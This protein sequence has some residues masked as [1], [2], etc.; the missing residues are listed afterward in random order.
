MKS[1]DFA[2]S[3][4]DFY[5]LNFAWRLLGFCY[6]H[7]KQATLTIL[8]KKLCKLWTWR[9]YLCCVDNYTGCK[10]QPYL[11]RQGKTRFLWRRLP[12]KV[13]S[14]QNIFL[15]WCRGCGTLRAKKVISDMQGAGAQLVVKTYLLPNVAEKVVLKKLF[16]VPDIVAMILKNV[17]EK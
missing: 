14:D 4:L 16:E 13:L 6:N 15:F 5:L 11:T 7:Q 8:T 2:W 12:A 1:Y 17:N 9:G 3:L 10:H